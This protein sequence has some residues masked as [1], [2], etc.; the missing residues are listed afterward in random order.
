MRCGPLSIA[1]IQCF[2]D[3]QLPSKAMFLHLRCL[4]SMRERLAIS[5]YSRS[6]CVFPSH[7]SPNHLRRQLQLS[8]QLEYSISACE[9]YSAVAAAERLECAV[10][11]KGEDGLS[12]LSSQPTPGQREA[13]QP[14]NI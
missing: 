4:G 10:V 8:P 3:Q 13:R 1:P 5:C 6:R 11:I 12:R 14:K 9:V 7:R 2:H